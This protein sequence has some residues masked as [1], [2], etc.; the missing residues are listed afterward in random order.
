MANS[1]RDLKIILLL[2][3]KGKLYDLPVACNPAVFPESHFPS[4]LALSRKQEFPR[5]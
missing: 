2:F 4:C 3:E 5:N 1:Q